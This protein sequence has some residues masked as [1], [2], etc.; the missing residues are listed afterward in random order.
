MQLDP[1]VAQIIVVLVVGAWAILT[2]INA[3]VPS[4][5]VP[6]A[7]NTLAL[8]V[9]GGALAFAKKGSKPTDTGGGADE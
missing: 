9:A 7:L 4:V 1:K 5:R 3:F 8:P 6:P 2:V